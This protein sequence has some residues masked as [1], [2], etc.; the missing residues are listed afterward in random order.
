VDAKFVRQRRNA[1]TI[2]HPL[3]RHLSERQGVFADSLLCH[4]Q[5]LSLLSVAKNSVSFRGVSPASDILVTIRAICLST[6]SVTLILVLGVWSAI[7]ETAAGAINRPDYLEEAAR[8][9]CAFTRVTMRC[10]SLVDASRY[11]S[12]L[13][14]KVDKRLKLVASR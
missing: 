11:L 14:L 8:A 1:G 7:C 5:F 3:H 13:S 4:S 2:L 10:E 9:F 6:I 12:A